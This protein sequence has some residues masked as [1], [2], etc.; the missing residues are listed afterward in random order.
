M[1]NFIPVSVGFLCAPRFCPT[2]FLVYFLKYHTLYML[3]FILYFLFSH[4]VDVSWG[5]LHIYHFNYFTIFLSFL[6]IAC[7]S[8]PCQNSGTCF[9]TLNGYRCL[10]AAGFTGTNCAISEF[11]LWFTSTLYNFNTIEFIFY[12]MQSEVCDIHMISR[13]ILWVIQV[14]C[15]TNDFVL[16]ILLLKIMF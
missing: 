2:K 9:T 10:C 16:F 13:Y 8:N 7:Q 11:I 5:Y 14:Y 4:R 12:L 15:D 1:V 3:K 6:D